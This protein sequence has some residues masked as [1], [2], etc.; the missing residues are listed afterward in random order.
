VL[1]KGLTSASLSAFWQQ[2]KE[3]P[4]ATNQTDVI[5]C[6]SLVGFVGKDTGVERL[7]P[8]TAS[9]EAVFCRRFTHKAAS[10]VTA[11]PTKPTKPTIGKPKTR[12][13]VWRR[14]PLWQACLAAT[15]L[16]HQARLT[17]ACDLLFAALALREGHAPDETREMLRRC[18]PRASTNPEYCAGVVR[19]AVINPA[20]LITTELA[21]SY[22]GAHPFAW[23]LG[24]K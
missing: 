22:A 17:A 10:V 14:A 24:L 11:K 9:K 19:R 12:P 4:T 23:E 15:R 1:V 7:P 13:R 2:A 16:P 18:T 21:T 6:E 3:Q 20:A 5:I 8:Q